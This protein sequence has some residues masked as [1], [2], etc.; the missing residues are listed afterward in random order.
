MGTASED[1][2]VGDAGAAVVEDDVEVGQMLV[3]IDVAQDVDVM[4]AAFDIAGAAAEGD[5]EFDVVQAA[6]EDIHFSDEFLLGP[7]Q[8]GAEGDQDVEAADGAQAGLGLAAEDDGA[9]HFKVGWPIAGE[10]E[11]RQAVAED[12]V[13]RVDNFRAVRAE[14]LAVTDGREAM[15]ELAEGEV[16]EI[17]NGGAAEAIA[18]RM[19]GLPAAAIGRSAGGLFDG[20][21]S[22]DG[23][24]PGE[25]EFVGEG[26][27]DD[28]DGIG[29][30]E[31]RLEGGDVLAEVVLEGLQEGGG[32]IELGE[33]TP[34]VGADAMAGIGDAEKVIDVGAAEVVVAGVAGGF[35]SLEEDALGIGVARVGRRNEKDA[36][37][38]W[39]RRWSN[40]KVSGQRE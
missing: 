27:S 20:E 2:G 39:V 11:L 31:V 12:A 19:A 7:G 28:G 36:A 13:G 17:A 6:G 18:Q 37:H 4:G 30:D 34:G 5:G 8:M 15:A 16:L 22:G 23:G 40:C 26:S 24:D 35:R 21:G 1:G 29:D 33:D 3:V 38:G 25:L 9:D 10:L 14:A 32:G